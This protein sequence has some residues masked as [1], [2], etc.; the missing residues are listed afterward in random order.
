MTSE[1]ISQLENNADMLS[2]LQEQ[3]NNFPA[4]NTYISSKKLYPSSIFLPQV[5][6]SIDNELKL[7]EQLIFEAISFL[8]IVK[9]FSFIIYN[10]PEHFTTNIVNI[11][12]SN[13]TLDDANSCLAIEAYDDF[14]FTKKEE[15]CE[16]LNNNK[17][18]L[19]I[20]ILSLISLI[21]YTEKS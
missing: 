5:L 14:L 3:L 15:V 4:L 21:F 11:I 19:S 20:Y 12:A 2:L 18:I 13:R 7:H 1:S 16:F 6:K 10:N 9:T 8:D 17:L